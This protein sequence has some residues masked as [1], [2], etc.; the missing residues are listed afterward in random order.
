V[1]L[2]INLTTSPEDLDRFASS[3]DLVK[4]LRG[5]DGVELM[6]Y[7]EDERK[8]IPPDRIVGFHMSNHNYWVDFWRQDKEALAREF[9]DLETAKASFGGTL[10]PQRLVEEF[11]RDFAL[12]K[13][14]GAQ[15][16]VWHVSDAGIE[17]SFTRRYRHTDEEV[18]DAAC[19]V[20]NAA[21]E[22]EKDASVALLLENLWLP[23]LRFTRPEITARLLEGV[24]YPNKGI[25]LDTGHLLHNELDLRDQA[26]GVAYIEKLL[27]AH[28]ALAKAVRGVHLNQSVTGDYAKSIMARP[29][30]L[31]KTYR[32]RSWKMFS[33]AYAVD[34]HQPFTAPGV[35]E[36]ILERIAPEFLTFEFITDDNAQHAQF[37]RQQRRALGLPLIDG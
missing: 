17:E 24:K 36:L 27:D 11:R 10:D 20:I 29:P 1:K 14:F 5:F 8:I 2:S 7:G 18:A 3:E 6:Y 34:K 25:M 13:R 32:E 16:A 31:G 35:R 19:E 4:L 33:H 23:G 28:G 9:D 26:E 22:G 30:E 12:A 37:L 15:Y 21:L